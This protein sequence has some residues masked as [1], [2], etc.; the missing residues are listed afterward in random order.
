MRYEYIGGGLHLDGVDLAEVATA[1][2]T[3]CYIYSRVGIESRFREYVGGFGKRRHRVCYSV[4]ANGNLSIISLLG[5]LGSGFDI[6]S[7]GELERVF[8]AGGSARDVVFSGVGKSRKE[9]DAAVEVQVGCINVESRAELERI[10]LAAEVC[11]KVAAIA[12]RVNPDVDPDTHPYISTGMRESKFGVPIDE[13]YDLYQVSAENKWLNP[14]GIACHIGSQLVSAEPVVD[15]LREVVAVA[16]K[17]RATNIDLQR[18]D[19]GGGLGIRYRDEC[20]PTIKS[21]VESI[22]AHVPERYEIVVEPGRSLVGDSGLLLTRV[23]YLKTTTE[24]NFAVVDAGMNDL[25][26]PALYDVWHNVLVVN[27]RN[28]AADAVACDVVGPVCETGDWLARDRELSV[29]DGDLLA[30]TAVGA[31]GF[32]MSSNYN[33]RPRAPEVLVEGERFIVIRPRES[34]LEMLSKERDC[35][36]C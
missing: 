25:I 22:C 10:A 11:G 3:P 13:V 27:Q 5:K 16:E 29:I 26:R 17:L 31:Y 15:A 6:V 32:A 28:T 33:A 9:I 24:K 18:I 12:I 35:M 7:G 19:V 36:I 23:E 4:K 8:A 1:V 30:I 2:G 21:F 14:V 20:P 34:T